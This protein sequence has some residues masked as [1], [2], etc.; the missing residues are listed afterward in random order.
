[1]ISKAYSFRRVTISTLMHMATI[2]L[3]IDAGHSLIGRVIPN[4][5]QLITIIGSLEV[6][7][8]Y[9]KILAEC[10]GTQLMKLMI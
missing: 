1:V 6:Q 4:D 10:T 8:N 5:A 9:S 3:R 2:A 7:F